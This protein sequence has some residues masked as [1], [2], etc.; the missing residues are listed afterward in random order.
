MTLARTLIVLP[1]LLLLA[2]APTCAE[3]ITIRFGHVVQRDT[4]K[5]KACEY[6]KRLIEQR[7]D[8]KIRVEIYPAGQLGDEQEI[9]TAL[10]SNRLQMAAPD[11]S[12]L[13]A[14][15][16]Q[17]QLFNLPFF[18]KDVGHL[19]RV[20]DGEVGQQLLADARRDG[21]V[22]LSFW[23]N[24][25]KQLTANREL[26]TPEDIAGLRIRITDSE[27]LKEQF[28]E[29]GAF[30]RVV[31]FPRLYAVLHNGEV[32]GQENTLSNI[33]SRQLFQVQSDLT[34]SNHGYLNYLVLTNAGFWAGLP[35]DLKVIIRG[36]IKDATEY[37]REMAVQ[38]N[39]Q[40]LNRMRESKLIRV[41]VL[42]Q[43]QRELWRTKLTGIYPRLYNSIDKNLLRKAQE[44]ETR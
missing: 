26:I 18:F 1:F 5:G 9:L 13:A 3:Q 11:V 36:A 30:P 40:A 29:L 19:H 7:S 34:I 22:P 31:P 27:V 39:L 6:F 33:Y 21:L 24:G 43:A 16:P 38:I 28:E 17:L 35:E 8:D 2:A 15:D 23:D 25:F 41:H 37:T 20:V 4:P 44:L 12:K 32:D 42:T 10:R 14:V